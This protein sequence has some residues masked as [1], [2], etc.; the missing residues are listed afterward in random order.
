MD[1]E[2]FDILHNHYA[3]FYKTKENQVGWNIR[4]L[5][6]HYDECIDFCKKNKFVKYE[7][8]L[9]PTF[10]FAFDLQQL[11]DIVY[12]N[13]KYYFPDEKIPYPKT[14]PQIINKFQSKIV[15]ESE[16]NE[17]D[18]YE[19][20]YKGIE[21]LWTTMTTEFILPKKKVK[22]YIVAQY[23]VKDFPKFLEKLESNKQAVYI[24]DEYTSFKW[25]AWVNGNKIRLIH[26]CYNFKKI[27][28]LFDVIVDKDWFFSFGHNL[29]DT[30]NQFIKSDLK[31]Y[32]KWKKEMEDKI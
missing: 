6:L 5:N 18:R 4:R 26:Q 3:V 25:L 20:Q 10:S 14:T 21:Q 8:I 13:R 11:T 23:F 17:D 7:I 12:L 22:T 31:L 27:K 19:E 29:L 9:T 2:K 16:W 1:K 28:R 24:N 32:E 30:M 15:W